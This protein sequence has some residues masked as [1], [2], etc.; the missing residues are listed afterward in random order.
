MIMEMNKTE[1]IQHIINE[2]LL[3]IIRTDNIESAMK[4]FEVLVEAGAKVIEF[5]S[6]IPNYQLAIK[7]A[8][9]S[10]K[11]EN[12]LIGAGTVLDKKLAL[13][14]IEG[15]PDF[16]VNPIQNFEILEIIP[17]DKVIFM[18]AFTPTEV[19]N[20]YWKGVDFIK[21]FPASTLGSKFIKALK[22]GPMPFVRILASG[23][24]DLEIIEEYIISGADVI[25]VGSEVV[26]KEL[27][28]SNNYEY[29]KDLAKKYIK[30]IENI[31]EKGLFS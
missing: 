7:R 30:K 6:T 18:G 12:I 24:M 2:K 19:I 16:V 22:G 11:G 25:G 4:C 20:N 10:I 23:G 1:K 27:V 31:K 21:V 13:Q 29:I 9:E 5:T 17:K 15:D 26:K 3:F 28:N 14:A 8:K